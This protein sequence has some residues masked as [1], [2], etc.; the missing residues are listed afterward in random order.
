MASFAEHVNNSGK[1]SSVRAAAAAL[2]QRLLAALPEAGGLEPQLL[3]DMLQLEAAVRG[4]CRLWAHSPPGGCF[5]D[6]ELH[7][8][9]C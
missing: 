7:D 8:W 5:D 2:L 9:A 4:V 6:A 1:G 3:S